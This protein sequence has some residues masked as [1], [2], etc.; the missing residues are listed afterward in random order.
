MGGLR[1]AIGIVLLVGCAAHHG[2]PDG[3]IDATLGP[4]VQDAGV[5]DAALDAGTDASAPFDAEV[6]AG[7]AATDAAPEPP[8]VDWVAH[9]EGICC[10]APRAMAT[11]PD[12]TAYLTGKYGCR[13]TV[14]GPASDS[15]TTLEGEARQDA[16]VARYS[17]T[18]ELEWVRGITSARDVWAHGA[19]ALSD[20]SVVVVGSTQGVTRF[21]DTTWDAGAQ[22][23]GFVAR[24]DAS[25]E[26]MW[27]ALVRGGE[28]PFPGAQVRAV[29]ARDD[30]ISIAGTY[31]GEAR[32]GSDED[33][34]TVSPYGVTD[35]FVAQLTLDGTPLW[36]RG[37]G[38][39]IGDEVHAVAVTLDGGAV[40]AGQFPGTLR[41]DRPSE[42]E[43]TSAGLG[44][45]YLAD[46]SPTGG[47]RWGVAIGGDANEQANAVSV[48]EAGHV[49]VGGVLSSNTVFGSGAAETTLRPSA[50]QYA[51]VAS[52]GAAGAFLEARLTGG[53]RLQG[54]D[55]SGETLCG[56]FNGTS[57]F[58]AGQPTAQTMAVEGM[59]EAYVSEWTED[60][61][62]AFSVQTAGP[63]NAECVAVARVPG[64]LLAAGWFAGVTEFRPGRPEPL[65]IDTVSCNVFLMRVAT[66]E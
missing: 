52:Y 6:D 12:G 1:G 23:A 32:F 20:G 39:P 58:G 15:E 31:S 5:S 25:G 9:T 40:I 56:H 60:G 43:I 34:L 2:T 29:A 10:N 61:Q 42:P 16:F 4:V 33:E 27:A 22:S 8:F 38:S 45:A 36:A 37:L 64:G 49:R 13:D 51:F 17:P 55:E 24:Y 63:G 65:A 7:D 66:T 3:G 54:M 59:R 28:G 18:G 30:R 19:A 26:L 35:I 50:G 47:L 11:L 46:F 21:A 62:H 57:T 14:F 41:T 44:D 48:T 53:D